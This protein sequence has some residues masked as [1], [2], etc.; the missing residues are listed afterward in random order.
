LKEK[1]LNRPEEFFAWFRSLKK[2]AHRLAL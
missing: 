1:H 2:R